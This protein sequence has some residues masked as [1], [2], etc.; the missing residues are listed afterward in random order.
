MES[1][2]VL[3]KSLDEVGI[4]LAAHKLGL[5]QSMVYKWCQPDGEEGARA[6]NPLD[7]LL[8]LIRLTKTTMLLDW[9]CQEAGG[10]YVENPSTQPATS[11]EVLQ[12]TQQMVG[13]FSQLLSSVTK[14]LSDDQAISPAEAEEIRRIWQ[15]LKSVGERF[16]AG[17]EAGR[18]RLPD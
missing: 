4:K 13:E 10:Y 3:K 1:H 2:E 5:S 6:V 15:S 14:S 9:L 16:V 17:C 8:E 11:V 7:R 18:F 12:A